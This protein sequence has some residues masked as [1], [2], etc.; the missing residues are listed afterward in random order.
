M[1]CQ[2]IVQMKKKNLVLFEINLCKKSFLSV[3]LNP[4]IAVL[5]EMQDPA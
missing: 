1:S 4:S 2:I 3:T 5:D